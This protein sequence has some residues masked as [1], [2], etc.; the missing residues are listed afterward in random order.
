MR[1]SEIVVLAYFTYLAGAAWRARVPA[2]R[3]WRV[4]A[5]AAFIIGFVFAVALVAGGPTTAVFR[6]WL[7][8]TYTLIGYWLPVL[9]TRAPH[10]RIEQWLL[11]LDDRLLTRTG[12]WSRI[13]RAPRAWLEYFELSYILCYPLVPAAFACFYLGGGFE[14]TDRFWTAVLLSVYPCYGLLPW[15]PTRAP[16]SLEGPGVFDRRRLTTRRLNLHVLRHGSNSWN[17]FPSGHAA[18]GVSAA[19]SVMLEMPLVGAALLLLAVSIM[20]G[21]VLGRYH[22]AADALAGAVMAI[23]A[24]IMAAFIA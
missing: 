21:S 15:L 1:S 17:T 7:P 23:A 6:D 19:L 12:V 18:G 22:Y 11:A 10:L 24:T 13:E 8:V 4:I 9:L 5:I 3:R 16:R 2:A 20:I 14:H